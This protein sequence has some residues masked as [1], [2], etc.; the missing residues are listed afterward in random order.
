MEVIDKSVLYRERDAKLAYER[1]LKFF[2]AGDRAKAK[3]MAWYLLLNHGV[4]LEFDD[5]RDIIGWD[6]NY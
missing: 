2:N 3:K 1:F 5:G 6:K 4:D